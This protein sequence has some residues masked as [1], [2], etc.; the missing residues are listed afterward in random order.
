M[1]VSRKIKTPLTSSNTSDSTR[2]P[3]GAII[4]Y[5]PG[6]TGVYGRS[7]STQLA[8]G[9][10]K[11]WA[12]TRTFKADLLKAQ[13]QHGRNKESNR[14]ICRMSLCL[15]FP[16]KYSSLARGHPPPTTW[17]H[18]QLPQSQ[19]QVSLAQRQIHLP[20]IWALFPRQLTPELS[21]LLSFALTAAAWTHQASS[22]QCPGHPISI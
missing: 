17:Q 11:D 5:Y 1:I 12:Y 8:G 2:F 13:E 15:G 7:V 22:E 6:C 14:D 3:M 16:A 10:Q 4:L 19:I 20:P 21:T 9:F 18:S